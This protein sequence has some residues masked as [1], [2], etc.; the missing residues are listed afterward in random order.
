MNSATKKPMSIAKF[1][2]FLV[3]IPIFGFVFFMFVFILNL[4][5]VNTFQSECGMDPTSSESTSTQEECLG[6]KLI[7]NSPLY[8]TFLFLIIGAVPVGELI[9][10][11]KFITSRKRTNQNLPST[12]E[13]S[14]EEQKL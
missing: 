14:N 7:E 5:E 6:M 12:V 10:I 2:L 1:L 9:L 8:I 11:W 13:L 4:K 3:G